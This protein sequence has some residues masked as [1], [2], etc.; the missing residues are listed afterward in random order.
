MT[1][2]QLK[3]REFFSDKCILITGVTGFVGKVLL[4]KLLSTIPRIGK[5][6]IMIRAKKGVE[7]NDRLHGEIFGSPLF[8]PLF[9]DKPELRK[10]VKER[11]VAIQGDLVIEKLGIDPVVREQVIAETQIILNSAASVSF[12]DPIKE[13]LEI[14]YFGTVRMLD[15]AHECKNLIAMHHV[16]TV[17][18]NCNLP[19]GSVIKEEI[20]PFAGGSYDYELLVREIVALTDQ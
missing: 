15:L 20:T 10:V 2:Q 1:S 14:N 11:V 3:V 16:S 13:A 5:L 6:Y 18:T 9:K 17:G 19:D 7:L 4:E 8:E 12:H